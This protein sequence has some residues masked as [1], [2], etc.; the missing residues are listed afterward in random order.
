MSKEQ[1]VDQSYVV[2]EWLTT[3]MQKVTSNPKLLGKLMYN[4]TQKAEEIVDAVMT[5]T[6]P[7]HRGV[8]AELL[9]ASIKMSA[10]VLSWK[11]GK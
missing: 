9:K 6:P 10:G 3:S 5:L 11:A 1:E 4:Y 8:V 2:L 7:E